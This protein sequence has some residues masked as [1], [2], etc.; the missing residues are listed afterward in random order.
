MK[1]LTIITLMTFSLINP[2]FSQD[3]F[4]TYEIPFLG[5][6]QEIQIIVKSETKYKYYVNM[7]SFDS[8]NP[9]GGVIVDQRTHNNFTKTLAEAKAKL[10]VLD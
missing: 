3:Y 2:V 9:K 6:S 10:K 7:L 1:T 8:N 5:T 4:A